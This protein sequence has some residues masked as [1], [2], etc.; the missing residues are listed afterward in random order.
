LVKKVVVIASVLSA[1]G[2][3]AM[4]VWDRDP[5][6]YGERYVSW[7]LGIGNGRVGAGVDLSGDGL[8]LTITRFRKPLREY[9]PGTAF[10]RTQKFGWFTGGSDVTGSELLG[11]RFRREIVLEEFR[12]R[13][14]WTAW[15]V[16]LPVWVLIAGAAVPGL[17]GWRRWAAAAKAARGRA[18]LCQRCGY[19]LRAT[20]ARCPECGAAPGLS[21]AAPSA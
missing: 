5:G 6:H 12:P 21:P 19:D 11:L 9:R 8:L 3:V 16:N 1:L 13:E 7:H 20:P 2:L 4:W 15:D 17:W 18:G 14:L 10:L